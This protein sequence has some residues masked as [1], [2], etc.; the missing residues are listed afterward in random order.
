MA[1]TPEPP[2]TGVRFAED[3]LEHLQDTSRPSGFAH[4]HRP[5]MQRAHSRDLSAALDLA[6]P[7]SFIQAC[8]S[9]TE[10]IVEHVQNN[11]QTPNP[12]V[13]AVR[14]FVVAAPHGRTL[15]RT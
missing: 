7:V 15:I 4:A 1:D 2:L 6:D 3:S 11:R 9:H 10:L 12:E 5:S 13:T 8:F 14:L